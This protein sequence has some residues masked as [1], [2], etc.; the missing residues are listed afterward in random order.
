MR[1]QFIFQQH[2]TILLHIGVFILQQ[3]RSQIDLD[4]LLKRTAVCRRRHGHSSGIDDKRCKFR[5]KTD[6]LQISLL[7]LQNSLKG[8]KKSRIYFLLSSPFDASRTD[9]ITSKLPIPCQVKCDRMQLACNILT[10]EA[11]DKLLLHLTAL[12][13]P[14]KAPSAIGIIRCGMYRKASWNIRCKT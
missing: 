7:K 12:L 13:S 14:A 11:T 2:L 5:F 1:T 9:S 6:L 3:R 8:L 10:L 4:Q